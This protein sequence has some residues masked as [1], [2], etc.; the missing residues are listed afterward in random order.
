MRG[1]MTRYLSGPYRS[2]RRPLTLPE[3]KRAR[4]IADA[5]LA[6]VRETLMVLYRKRGLMRPTGPFSC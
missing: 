2:G 3:A 5:R 6:E 1:S 4:E